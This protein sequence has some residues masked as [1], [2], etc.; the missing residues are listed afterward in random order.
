MKRKIIIGNWK[1]NPNTGKVAS[2][3]F[4]EAARLVSRSKKTEIVICPPFI[5]LDN[6]S[7]I[8][9][10]KIKLGAQDT[11]AENPPAGGGPFTGEVS[12]EMLYNLGVGY[13]ILGHSERRAFGENNQIVNKKIKGALS[14]GLRPIVCVG[15]EERD[16]SHKYFDIVKKQVKECLA[17]ISRDSFHK[18]ILAYEPIWSISTTKARRDAVPDDSREMAVF[19]RKTLSDIT[20]PAIANKVR[21]LYGGSVNERDAEGFLRDG[22]VDGALVGQASLSVEKFI[23]IVRICEALKN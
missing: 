8:R 16:E 13:V 3:W 11:F 1:M 14:A 5:Y 7:R 9:T 22:R 21:I 19:I 4:Q 12:S 23:E 18:I 20:T 17:G 6:L 2:K 10:S 15:E